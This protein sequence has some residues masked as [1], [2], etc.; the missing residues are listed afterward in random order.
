MEYLFID[1]SGSMST[2]YINSYPYFVI[3]IIHPINKDKLKIIL[4]RFISKKINTWIKEESKMVS[5]GKFKEL[6]G[7]QLSYNEKIELGF[8][9]IDN[10]YFE[11]YYI[12]VINGKVMDRLYYNKARAFNYLLDESLYLNLKNGN[13]PNDDYFIQIDERNIKNGSIKSLE[14]Y[15]A[16][17]FMIKDNLINSLIV[18]YFD[19]KDNILIQLADF[20]SNLY[21][22]YLM[23]KS[24]YNELIM[25]LRKKKIIKN[26]FIFPL[27]IN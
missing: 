23:H 17:H 7:S 26:E 9:L 16:T 8:Y 21:Y 19:S 2:K 14:D 11:V 6:K 24:S 18:E 1:E 10:N 4:K 25:E 27:N 13:L 20:F 22:S 3:C 12:N 15:L 5:N